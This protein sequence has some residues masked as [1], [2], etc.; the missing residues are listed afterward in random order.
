M[1]IQ[2]TSKSKLIFLQ[3]FKFQHTIG[4]NPAFYF[5][6]SLCFFSAAE[7][8]LN[9]KEPLYSWIGGKHISMMLHLMGKT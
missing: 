3:H 6:A 9:Y 8:I 4:K 5:Q 7:E 1:S 2:E